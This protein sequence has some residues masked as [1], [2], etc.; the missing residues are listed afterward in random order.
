[1]LFRTS[2]MINRFLLL[3]R[4]MP[5]YYPKKSTHDSPKSMHLV[6]TISEKNWSSHF[7]QSVELEY[8]LIAFLHNSHTTKV[9]PGNELQKTLYNRISHT[10]HC[11]LDPAHFLP[12]LHFSNVRLL[13]FS[14]LYSSSDLSSLALFF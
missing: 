7:C 3:A 12:F 9:L 10:V 14:S 1:M 6:T 11:V 4:K 13:S 8:F 2:H 5:L